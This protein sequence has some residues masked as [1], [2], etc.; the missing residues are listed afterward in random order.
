MAS[1]SLLSPSTSRLPFS[2]IFFSLIKKK[3]KDYVIVIYALFRFSDKK[4]HASFLFRI[5][6]YTASLNAPSTTL[7][8]LFS[9]LILEN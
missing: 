3:K 8:F 5:P 6:F 7:R 4:V 1:G 2:N 9:E